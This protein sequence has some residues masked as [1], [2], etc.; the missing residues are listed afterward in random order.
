[1]RTNEP[2]QVP[3]KELAYFRDNHVGFL[4]LENTEISKLLL[5]QLYYFHSNRIFSIYYIL[6]EIKYLEGITKA[7][8]T[9]KE[10]EFKGQYLR[11][12]WHKHFYSN[13]FIYTNII[14]YWEMKKK[15]NSKL[16]KL[17]DEVFQSSESDYI[18]EEM[19]NLFA[20]KLTDDPFRN[21]ILRGTCTGEW[22]VF[23]KSNN[24]NYYLVL[25]Q[26]NDDENIY[27]LIS[28]YCLT[29]YPDL[30]TLIEKKA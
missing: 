12:L 20:Y 22:I 10:E 27:K 26:H 24:K 30:K 23:A 7:T 21:K 3:D 1:M 13:R 28:R 4:H 6:D 16:D 19:I 29:E 18:T 8:R 14:N 17:I 5:W 25:G 11:G 9:K 15:A 2:L